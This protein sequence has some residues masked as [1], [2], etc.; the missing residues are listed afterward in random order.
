MFYHY[1]LFFFFF[2]MNRNDDLL[3]YKLSS[4]IIHVFLL[5]NSFRKKRNTN[6]SRFQVDVDFKLPLHDKSPMKW[7]VCCGIVDSFGQSWSLNICK[8]TSLPR[9]TMRCSCD[10]GGLFAIFAAK[11]PNV[12]TSL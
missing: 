11:L 12:R 7:E 5:D 6:S 1:H 10:H 3:L 9:H 2:C 8:S 4:P